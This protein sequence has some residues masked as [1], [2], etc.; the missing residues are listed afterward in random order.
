MVIATR[1]E[2]NGRSADERTGREKEKHPLVHSRDREPLDEFLAEAWRR[3]PIR[4]G[5]SARV[6]AA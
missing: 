2:E 6:G 1:C 3:G 5:A 4:K